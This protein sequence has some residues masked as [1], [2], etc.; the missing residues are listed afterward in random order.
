MCWRNWKF[1]QAGVETVAGKTRRQDFALLK[2]HA[3]LGQLTTLE[4]VFTVNSV[5]V[6]IVWIVYAILS[7]IHVF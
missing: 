5:D 7:S 4:C 2:S 1:A 6:L 3:M